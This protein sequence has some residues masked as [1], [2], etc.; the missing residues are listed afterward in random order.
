MKKPRCCTTLNPEGCAS[1][2]KRWRAICP[3]FYVIIVRPRRGQRRYFSTMDDTRFPLSDRNTAPK[4]FRSYH[5]AM[6]TR[7]ELLA[8]KLAS[9]AH[10]REAKILVRRKAEE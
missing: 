3:G 8:S 4:L 2:G 1:C 6:E 7:N 9:T 10:V 5:V